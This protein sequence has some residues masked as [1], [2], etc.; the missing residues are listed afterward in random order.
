MSVQFAKPQFNPETQRRVADVM[1]ALDAGFRS[2]APAV[3]RAGEEM[4]RALSGVR[5]PA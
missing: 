1:Q 3:Q 5:R 2:L 4:G